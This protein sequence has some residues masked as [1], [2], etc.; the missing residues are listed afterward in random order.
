MAIIAMCIPILAGKKEKWQAMMDQLTNDPNFA[1]SREGIDEFQITLDTDDFIASVHAVKMN[2]D[3]IEKV[4]AF[5]KL[6]NGKAYEWH[7][8]PMPTEI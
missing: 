5:A 3:R 6:H 4:Y 1:A 2:D 8:L 7:I